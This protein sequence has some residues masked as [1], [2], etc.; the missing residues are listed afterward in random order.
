MHTDKRLPV[1]QSNKMAALKVVVVLLLLLATAISTIGAAK[2]KQFSPE[3]LYKQTVETWQ[4]KYS[5][6]TPTSWEVWKEFATTITAKYESIIGKDGEFATTTESRPTDPSAVEIVGAM[7]EGILTIERIVFQQQ[8][9]ETSGNIADDDARDASL[10]VLYTEYGRLLMYS[11]ETTKILDDKKSS[12]SSRHHRCHELAKDPHTLLIGAPERLNEYRKKEDTLKGDDDDEKDLLASLF[13]SLC[14][15]NA[16]N[17]LRN[18]ISL[19]ANCNEA[20]KLLDDIIATSSS[21][22]TRKP[23]EFVAE[24]FDSF[25]DIFDEKLTKTLD[26]RVPQIIGSKVAELL[27]ERPNPT[28]LFRNV[29]DAGCGTGLAGRELRNAIDNE[30]NTNGNQRI[31]LVGVDASPKMLEIAGHCTNS[32]GCGLPTKSSASAIHDDDSRPLYN[33]LIDLDLEEM[34]L[35]NTLLVA[36]NTTPQQ[37]DQDT[38]SFDLIVAADVFVYFGSLETILEVF[39]GLQSTRDGGGTLV[40]TC[41]RTTPEESPLGYRLLPTGRFAH[42]RDH[43][44][45][46]ASACG[47][48]LVDYSEIVPR[49]EKGVAVDGHLFVFEHTHT[50]GGDGTVTNDKSEL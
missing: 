37:Q 27:L 17:A 46:A 45:N 5:R 23:K 25:A 8:E 38:S 26:Y 44:V 34:T 3:K 16:E 1:Q 12:E 49:T 29:L 43:A 11:S 9:Q 10:A 15:D 50:G 42:T 22:D 33:A 20:K 41:E 32:K 7:E 13:G 40:F 18:A 30:N 36:A 6:R 47:Y 24:L 39:S 35:E 28:A 14:R 19:D 21:G 4:Q 2:E 48:S 31:V